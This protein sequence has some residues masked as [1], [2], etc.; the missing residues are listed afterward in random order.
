VR[1]L[2]ERSS[3]AAQEISRLIEESAEHVRAGAEVSQSAASS[4]EDILASV[5]RTVSRAS[6]IASTTE[7]QRA[8]AARV[9]SLIHELT[10]AVDQK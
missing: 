7:E 5:E 8:L 1:K 4:F 10:R 3:T 9:G 6:E 2:A